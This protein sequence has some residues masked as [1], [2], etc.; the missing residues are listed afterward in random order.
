MQIDYE[1]TITALKASST[2]LPPNPSKNFIIQLLT[3]EK[4]KIKTSIIRELSD[5]A[6]DQKFINSRKIHAALLSDLEFSQRIPDEF[7]EGMRAY[8][9]SVINGL[10]GG[11]LE[12]YIKATMI[13]LI[14]G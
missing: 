14:A 12:Q 2:Y 7:T 1:S 5:T 8:L 11:E 13:Y 6:R 3:E 4:Y 10:S 9:L